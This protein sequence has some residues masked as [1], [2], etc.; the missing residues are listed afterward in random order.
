MATM[1]ADPIF[2]D[3]NVLIYSAVPT[4]PFHAEA[5]TNLQELEQVG[6]E[7]WVSRQIFREFAAALTLPQ[8]FTAALSP[9][10][11]VAAIRKFEVSF[12]IAEDGAKVTANLLNVL[13]TIPMGGKQI[14]DANIVATMQA[15]G[16]KNLLTHNVADFVRY[17]SLITVVP[18][19]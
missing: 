7:V 18:L 13:L 11:I 15:H 16:I 6:A 1:G 3:T 8:S 14:H 4:A 2:V 10:V 5:A 17:G 19:V 12:R 9:A